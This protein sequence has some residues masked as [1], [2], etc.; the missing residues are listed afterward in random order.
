MME[1]ALL[2]AR[3]ARNLRLKQWVYRPV[4]AL[5]RLL[6][7]DVTAIGDVNHDR[8]EQLRS[9]VLAWGPGEPRVRIQRAQEVARS[10]FRFL[11]HVE[12]LQEIDWSHRYV[13][14]L[15][16]YN[17]HYFD[18]AL[19]LAWAYY[20]ERDALYVRT[21][22]DLV[23]SWIVGAADRG[24]DGWEPYPTSLRVVNW[25]YALLL[26]D[27]VIS[28]GVRGRMVSSLLGQVALLESR[29]EFHVLANHLQ[30]N[31]KTLAIAGLFFC[32]PSPDRWLDN[33]MQGLWTE[34]REQVLPDGVHYERSPMYHAIALADFLEVIALRSAAQMAIPADARDRVQCMISAFGVL[35]RPD[36]QLHLFNDAAHNVAP[37]RRTI[38]RLAQQLSYEPAPNRSGTLA[39]PDG[40]YF[41][42]ADRASGDRILIDCGEPGPQYQ[43]GH[44]HCDLL[45]F[46]LD[47]AGRNVVVDAGVHGYAG[48]PLRE[49]VRST[50]AHN[51]VMI[52]F[53]EQAEIWGSFRMARRPEIVSAVASGDGED[54]SFTGAYRPYHDRAATHQRQVTRH[55]GEWLVTD[56]VEGATNS[57]LTSFLHLHP[58]FATESD[59]V[60]VVARSSFLTV[61]I[62]PFG[63]DRF[64]LQRGANRPH[65]GWYCPEFGQAIAAPVIEMT[66]EKNRNECFGYRIR[67]QRDAKRG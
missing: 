15:W 67:V 39:L 26:L 47:L 22:E 46:E 23:E 21:L 60:R 61:L 28:P 5:Q 56:K 64:D 6:P 55:A 52:A 19:D 24:S 12:H 41:G 20:L 38:V 50:R 25:I 33:G 31:Y 10:E 44:A 34:L 42:W 35:C 54:F 36:G 57:V 13:S 49:Y 16:T 17:L 66:V 18:F 53:K 48:G 32:G 43:P 1:R 14:H 59:G 27:G 51:T 9:A 11:N 45:S 4:R 58:N 40:G 29:L 7:S 8:L 30:K 2:F 62:E 37:S 63:V 65:Q 3:T